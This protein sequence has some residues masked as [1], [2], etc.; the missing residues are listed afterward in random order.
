MLIT[1]EVQSTI[2]LTLA[3]L[4]TLPQQTRAVTYE[5]AAGTEQPTETGPFVIDVL[6]QAGLRLDP[7][8]P[9][10][11]LNLTVLVVGASG[12][13]AALSLGELSPDFGGTPAILSLSENG[14]ALASGPQLVVPGDVRDS[15]Y[16][17]GVVELRVVRVN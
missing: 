13:Q 8:R 14:V 16:V 3:D 10:D 2:R 15:R 5:G 9:N 11:I 7:N 1:G 6:N 12:Q 4:A 17:T